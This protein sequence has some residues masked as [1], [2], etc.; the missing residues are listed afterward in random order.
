MTGTGAC[1]ING[2]MTAGQA[3]KKYGRIEGIS[4]YCSW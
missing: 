4:H 2:L 3:H 1:I